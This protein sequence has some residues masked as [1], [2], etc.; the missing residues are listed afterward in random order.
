MLILVVLVVLMIVGLRTELF[1]WMI[2]LIFVLI[3]SCGL[4]GNGK[5]VLEVIVELSSEE[6]VVCVFLIVSWIE[7]MWFI[8]FVLILMEV[9]LL[10]S[11]IVFECMCL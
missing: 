10:E 8:W 5:N 6:F 2:V 11:M 3:V 1:G 7:F 9:R 4:F